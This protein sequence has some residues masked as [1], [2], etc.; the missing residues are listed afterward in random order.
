MAI[1]HC[2]CMPNEICRSAFLVAIFALLATGLAGCH[3]YVDDGEGDPCDEGA[4]ADDPVDVGNP[5][6]G[7]DPN[8]MGNP[9]NADAGAGALSCT[10]NV[11]CGAGCYCSDAG[12]CE[13]AGF[14]QS[15]TDCQAGFECD[16]R[17]TCV[18]ACSEPDE[19]PPECS[20][21]SELTCIEDATCSS[22][23]RGVNCTSDNGDE[24]TDGSEDCTCESFQFDYCEA[25]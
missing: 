8:D 17:D 11:G 24:C 19:A 13:E 6:A 14:C 9:D 3:L 22:V 23:Y 7:V 16:D 12:F 1:A 15:D 21:L 18:P 10:A 2:Q 4:C 20:D 5:D 25:V